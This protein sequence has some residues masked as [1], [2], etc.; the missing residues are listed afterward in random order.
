MFPSVR[1]ASVVVGAVVLALGACTG[2]GGSGSAPSPTVADSEP[3]TVVVT[4]E[5][6]KDALG[7]QLG[8]ELRTW[9]PTE[10]HASDEVNPWVGE[11]DLIVDA[12]PFSVTESIRDRSKVEG[13]TSTALAPVAEIPA[14][15]YTLIVW[16]RPNASQSAARACK[17]EVV[18]LPG[19][20]AQ[21]TVTDMPGDGT[22]VLPC[23]TM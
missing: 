15:T 4:V 8:A 11:F 2:S 20:T 17:T 10:P 9:D 22:N 23:P 13:S 14:G 5:S 18:V 3:A 6:V 19:K 1:G 7:W 21:V 16:A 12:D